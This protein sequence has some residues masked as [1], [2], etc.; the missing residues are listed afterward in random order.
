MSGL[1]CSGLIV[2]ELLFDDVTGILTFSDGSYRAD[3]PPSTDLN[4]FVKTALVAATQGHLSDETFQIEGSPYVAGVF[5][6]NPKAE[7]GQL[8]LFVHVLDGGYH[9]FEIGVTQEY[10]NRLVERIRKLQQP[11]D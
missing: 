8:Q 10:L 9:N 1:P 4:D 7:P 3:I 11:K 2:P 5:S 6:R